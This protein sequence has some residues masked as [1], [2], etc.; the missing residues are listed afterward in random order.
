MKTGPREAIDLE[1]SKTSS[2]AQNH[3]LMK[4]AILVP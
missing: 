2:R 1:Q 4:A 3:A